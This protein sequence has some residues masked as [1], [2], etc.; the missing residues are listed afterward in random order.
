MYNKLNRSSAYLLYNM[1]LCITNC[2]K[3]LL[4]LL[5]HCSL[6]SLETGPIVRLKR[7][8]LRMTFRITTIFGI[9]TIFRIT[10]IFVVKG[11]DCYAF[12]GVM[13]TDSLFLKASICDRIHWVVSSVGSRMKIDYNIMIAYH[14]QTNKCF[15]SYNI[16]TCYPR[17]NSGLYTCSPDLDPSLSGLQ[18]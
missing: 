11:T 7:T 2:Y 12:I 16:V 14:I 5:Q 8:G 4:A 6:G 10:T 13:T 17:L 9:T 1:L 15:R 18:D 3:L